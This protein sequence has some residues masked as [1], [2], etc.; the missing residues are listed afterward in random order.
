MEKALNRGKEMMSGVQR[1]D[2][3]RAGDAADGADRPP[4]LAIRTPA[5]QRRDQGHG[6][7][8]TFS[9]ARGTFVPATPRP[10]GEMLDL[11]P[12]RCSPVR[13]PQNPQGVAS[14]TSPE[15]ARPGALR[16]PVPP[17]QLNPGRKQPC[18]H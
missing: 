4:L 15:R 1:T 14:G 17:E 2:R 6:T 7:T 8:G 5:G 16:R 10:C 3:P 12:L 13:R 18:V 9:A 11:S